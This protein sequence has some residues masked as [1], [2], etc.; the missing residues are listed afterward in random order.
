[1]YL[2]YSLIIL[3]LACGICLLTIPF[4]ITKTLFSR[5]FFISALFVILFSLSLYQLT[6]NHTA[7]KQWITQ[8]EKHYQ[9]QQEVKQLGGFAGIIKRIKKKL[10]ENPEDAEGWFILG[11]L[12]LANHDYNNAIDALGKAVK[13]R[14]NDQRI[15][16]V[17]DLAIQTGNANSG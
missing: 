1:M 13:L 12:Y 4:I 6:G 8:G 2:L 7:L 14:P 11:K 16:H 5:Y 17:Y 3:M 9:L 15:K 10:A